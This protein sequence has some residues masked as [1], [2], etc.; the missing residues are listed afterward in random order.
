MASRILTALDQAHARMVSDPEHTGFRLRFYERLADCELFMM[1]KSEPD[2]DQV[3][4]EVFPVEDKSY[5]L[6]F[7]TEARMVE[8]TET[9][10]PFV[11]LSGRKI[12]EMLDEQDLGM[13]LNLGVAPSSILIPSEAVEWLN[14]ALASE[15]ERV[16]GQPREVGAPAGLPAEFLRALDQK[17][18]TTTGLADFAYLAAVT[19]GDG[20]RSHLLGFVNANDEAHAA[21]TAVANE[22]VSFSDTE[23]TLD[24]GFFAP[25]DPVCERLNK[26][27]LK[28]DIPQ[29]EVA[30]ARSIAAPGMDP[31]KPP[32]LK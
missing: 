7:D 15:V 4:P 24:I 22:A 27:A 21:L 11:A 19:Y 18:A 12:A 1:L 8:F 31:Q 25:S 32:I 28:F 17:L 26:V 16:R 13:G 9:G 23:I 20:E 6:V 2:G 10:T 3:A 14:Q 5:V 30:P 29:P